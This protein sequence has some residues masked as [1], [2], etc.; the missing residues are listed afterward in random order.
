MENICNKLA[1]IVW[2]RGLLKKGLGK[3]F[4]FFILFIEKIKSFLKLFVM[5]MEY[6]LF[7]IF[8][9]IFFLF[10]KKIFKKG[11]FGNAIVFLTIYKRTNDKNYLEKFFQFWRFT[12]LE[13]QEDYSPKDYFENKIEKMRIEDKVSF[14]DG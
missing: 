9:L 10:F 6:K 5:V 13:K 8:Q 7:F 2:E 12:N 4:H 14:F 3:Y 1:V 11:V